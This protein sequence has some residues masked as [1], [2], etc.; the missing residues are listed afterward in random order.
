VTRNDL[1]GLCAGTYLRSLL[2]RAE[3]LADYFRQGATGRNIQSDLKTARAALDSARVLHESLGASIG[4]LAQTDT[5]GE[6]VLNRLIA[7]VDL[8]GTRD[9]DAV[10]RGLDERLTQVEQ[11]QS[12][13]CLGT[14]RLTSGGAALP[15]TSEQHQGTDPRQREQLGDRTPTERVGLPSPSIDSHRDAFGPKLPSED[16]PPGGQE[17]H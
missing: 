9:I 2:A 3:K 5:D 13:R 16:C 1:S 7:E 4:S 12:S 15:G 8:P 17:T 6:Q 11:N 14:G 10:V